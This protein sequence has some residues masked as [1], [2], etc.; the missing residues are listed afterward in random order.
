MQKVVEWVLPY[1]CKYDFGRESE[2]Q[3]RSN[4]RKLLDNIGLDGEKVRSRARLGICNRRRVDF[5]TQ[6]K[7]EMD[8]QVNLLLQQRVDPFSS[9]FGSPRHASS[10]SWTMLKQPNTKTWIITTTPSMM[11]MEMS[12]KRSK[13]RWWRRRCRPVSRISH[14]SHRVIRAFDLAPLVWSLN[15]TN[16]VQYNVSH[17]SSICSRTTIPWSHRLAVMG[18]VVFSLPAKNERRRGFVCLCGSPASPSIHRT[19]QLQSSGKF[20][21][22]AMMKSSNALKMSSSYLELESVECL[23]LIASVISF[24]N[25]AFSSASTSI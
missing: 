2:T 24:L 16:A 6:C 22:G 18:V 10:D 19:M 13:R 5:Q 9:P 20:G 8:L 4:G 17:S 25:W 12:R 15:A 1:T 14:K 11:T 23:E 3:G 21:M 7:V